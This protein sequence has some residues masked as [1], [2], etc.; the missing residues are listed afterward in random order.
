MRKHFLS[1]FA[2]LISAQFT[3]AVTSNDYSSLNGASGST[4]WSAVH[5][6]AKSGY[7]SLSYAGLWT[8][9]KTTDSYKSGSTYKIYD[10]YG[11]C[12]F[13]YSSDQCGSYSGECDCYNRE[14]SIPKSWFGGSESSNTPGT[15]IFHVVPTDGQINNTRSNYAFGEVGTAKTTHNTNG[16]VN[17]LSTSGGGKSITIE[18]TML[19]TSSTQSPGSSKQVFEPDDTYKGDFAR[20]Y[21]GTLLKWAG[22]YQA[23]TTDDGSVIF[24]GTYT[25]AGHWGLTEYGIALLLKWHRQDPVSQREIDRNNGIES[26]QG[27]RNPFIDY[28]ILAEYIWGKYAGNQFNTGNAVGSFESDFEPGVSDGDKASGPRITLSDTELTLDA[29]APNGSSSK[30]F[31]VTGADLTAKITITNTS[32]SGFFSVSPSEITSNYNGTTTIIVTYSPTAEGN[33]SAIF[34]IASSGASNKTITVSGKCTA[35][36][37]ATWMANGS[38]VG[39]STAESGQSPSVP[40]NPADCEGSNG[41]KFV[42]WTAQ[43]SI[44]GNSAPTD[45][46]TT[47]APALTGDKTFYA[48]YATASGST[49]SSIEKSITFS[50]QGYTSGAAITTVTMDNCTLTFDKGTG[51]NAPAYYTSGTAIRCYKGNT[52]TISSDNA[53]SS[54]VVSTASGYAGTISAN[55]GTYSGGTWTGSSNSVTLTH[56]PSNTNQWRITAITVTTGGGS[57]TTYSDYSTVCTTCSSYTTPTASFA[58]STKSTTCDGSVTNNLNTVSSGAV[59]YSS[60]DESVATVSGTGVVTALKAGQT[61]ITANIGAIDCYNATS[62]SYTL[63]VNRQSASA[64]FNNPTTTVQEGSTVTNVV[65][66]TG[67]GTITYSSS[68]PSVATVDNN[69]VVTGVAEGTARITASVAQ[70]SC[71]N[72]TSAYYDIEVTALPTYTVTFI[73]NGTTFLTQIGHAGEAISGLGTPT[74]TDCEDYT[75][76]GW[77]TEELAQDNTVAPTTVTPTTIPEGGTT[78]YAVYTKS[79]TTGGSGGGSTT[80]AVSMESLAA[81][82]GTVGNFEFSTAKNNGS[83]EPTYN[84]NYKDLRIYAKGSVT[85]SSNT[86]MTG[87]VFNLSAQGK[88]RLAPIT[89]SVGTIAAQAS[90]DETV[91][92]SGSANSV[93]FTVGDNANYGSD[94]SSKAGQL[95]FTSVD[96]TTGSGGGGTTTVYHTTAPDCSCE[97]TI[98]IKAGDGGTVEFE[99]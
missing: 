19:G 82:S 51:S 41:K 3:W 80:T 50:E 62:A 97:A 20:G 71:Y 22:D 38:S 33:H 89:A 65:T 72:A 70:S 43:A 10:M 17:K 98:T 40:S 95:C 1:L 47:S 12:P 9:Y 74:L 66:T 39:T 21:M 79:V 44:S 29:T 93:T 84:S 99:D 68:N 32:G 90:G 86:A 55:V 76:E 64:S 25:Q 81:A 30:T 83:T 77:S 58:S 54:I 91:T 5:A 52:L 88:K 8:A 24:S 78:Y 37:T 85:I 61:T 35:V 96:I 49:A 92:W 42:G 28:P 73:N 14:H 59:T 23:F 94:G 6:K 18:N 34:T 36:Y 69:G 2:L 63:T 46:F 11:G 60:S 26:T 75:F 67:D 45:M 13:T 48:V 16:L 87:I 27:N 7:S 15:D 56:S 4:L 31:T 53:I 57:S